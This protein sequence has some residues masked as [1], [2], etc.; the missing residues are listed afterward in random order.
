MQVELNYGRRSLA[1]ELPH[2]LQLT[3]VRKPVF[4]C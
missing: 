1:V 3:T 2:D 4:Q